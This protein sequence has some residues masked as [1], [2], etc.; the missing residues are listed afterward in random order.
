LTQGN[1]SLAPLNLDNFKSLYYALNAKP[2]YDIRLLKGRK[3]I[4]REDLLAIN[5]EIQDKLTHYQLNGSMVSVEF[6]LEKGRMKSFSAWEEFERERWEQNQN[7]IH[8]ITIS[9]DFMVKLPNFDLPQRH[10]LKVKLGN[11]IAP[12]DMI[13]LLFTAEDVNEILESRAD[14]VVKVSFINLRLASEL[15]DIVENWFNCLEDNKKNTP[16][17]FFILKKQEVIVSLIKKFLPL[18][19]ILSFYFSRLFE[20]LELPISIRSIE[21]LAIIYFLIAIV[22]YFLSSVFAGFFERHIRRI[23][24]HTMFCVTAGDK[25]DDIKVEKNN[26]NAFKWLILEIFSAVISLII[27]FFSTRLI[28]GLF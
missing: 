15:L 14:A 6:I 17:V 8:A 9:W 20:G 28:A 21:K 22:S 23:D 10:T 1:K 24:I 13:N 16:I 18:L 25:N 12:K 19:F 2:D 11:A 26:N 4:K 5:Y 27:T 7:K 3:R